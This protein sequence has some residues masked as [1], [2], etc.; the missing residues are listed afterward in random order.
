MHKFNFRFFEL[1]LPDD[2][3]V[4]TF[5]SAVERIVELCGSDRYIFHITYPPQGVYKDTLAGGVFRGLS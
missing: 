1:Y 3:S 2:T 4:Y 5:K